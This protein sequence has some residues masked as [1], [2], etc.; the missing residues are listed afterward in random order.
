VNRLANCL[1]A[2]ALV[3]AG[4][5]AASQSSPAIVAARQAGAV[6]ERYDGYLGYAANVGLDVR[7]QVGAV[8]IQRR[9]LYSDL[10]TRRRATAQEV[11]IAAGCQLLGDVKVGE[12]YMLNDGAWR[13]RSAGQPAP[14]P[15]YCGR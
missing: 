10:A 4:S 1:L 6:G 13:R 15:S 2:G 3:I 5:P 8:N 11:G 9:S 12:S 14:V 7:R